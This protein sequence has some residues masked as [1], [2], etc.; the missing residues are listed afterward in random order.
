MTTR[1]P[2]TNHDAH[3]HLRVLDGGLAATARQ[4]DEPAER[5]DATSL[6]AE[7]AAA[8]RLCDELE[9]DGLQITFAKDPAG[10]RIRAYVMDA[11]GHRAQD[12]SL[13]QVVSPEHLRMMG[14]SG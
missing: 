12:L 9:Q 13:A 8:A 11:A 3:S 5:L 4:E 2:T 10:G 14:A 7:I 6:A 1:T